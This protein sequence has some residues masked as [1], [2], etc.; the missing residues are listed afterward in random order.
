[1]LARY[2]IYG[3]IARLLA[4]PQL[5]GFTFAQTF[6]EGEGTSRLPYVSSSTG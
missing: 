6:Q 5:I 1:M 4:L 3:G 2:L